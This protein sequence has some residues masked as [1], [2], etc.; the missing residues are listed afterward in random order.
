MNTIM[1]VEK[2]RPKTVAEVIGNEDAKSSFIEWLI[3]QP[4]PRKKAVLL[5]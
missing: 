4:R 2:Y 1:W 3:K 5:D